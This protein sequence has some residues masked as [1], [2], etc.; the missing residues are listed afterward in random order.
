[1]KPGVKLPQIT[2]RTRVRD[3][4]VGGPNPFRWQ[5]MST[6]DYFKGKRVILFSLPGAFTPTCSTYQPINAMV[7]D[8]AG[9]DAAKARIGQT[10]KEQKALIQTRLAETEHEDW[11]PRYM[12]FPMTSYLRDDGIR[13]IEDWACDKSHYAGQEGK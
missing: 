7:S 1:M 9:E 4:A 3:E 10:A 6:D 5:D 8:I 11:L 13:A 12:A 2:F